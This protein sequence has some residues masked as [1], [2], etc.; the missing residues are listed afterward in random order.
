MGHLQVSSLSSSSFFGFSDSKLL[1]NNKA[2]NLAFRPSFCVLTSGVLS[3]S[4][5]DLV[6]DLLAEADL[7]VKF[8][9]KTL[10][11]T[12]FRVT[13]PRILDSPVQNFCLTTMI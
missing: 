12:A 8:S 13:L 2:L 5:F 6:F 1:S 11:I 4:I 3:F 9:R 7:A 10:P